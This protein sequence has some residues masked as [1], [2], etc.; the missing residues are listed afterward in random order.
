MGEASHV[1]RGQPMGGASHVGGPNHVGGAS[2]WAGSCPKVKA[3]AAVWAGPVVKRSLTFLRAA[4]RFAD[5]TRLPP[6]LSPWR[7]APRL[8]GLRSAAQCPCLSDAFKA[9]PLIC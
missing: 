1:G 4:G 6:V 7:H 9:L 3:L 2:L 8:P 5:A